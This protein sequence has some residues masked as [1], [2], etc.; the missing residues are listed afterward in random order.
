MK[1]AEAKIKSVGCLSIFFLQVF[2]KDG[3]IYFNSGVHQLWLMFSGR[4]VVLLVLSLCPYMDGWMSSTLG[5]D[6]GHSLPFSVCNTSNFCPA[7]TKNDFLPSLGL[8]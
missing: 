1:S 7:C 6:L 8:S 5:P 4:G 3:Q 2:N